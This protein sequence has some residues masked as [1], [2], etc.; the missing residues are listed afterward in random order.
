MI[1]LKCKLLY[2][3]PQEAVAVN[4]RRLSGRNAGREAGDSARERRRT[5]DE[6]LTQMQ[7]TPST[8]TQRQEH[9]PTNSTHPPRSYS[10]PL[11]YRIP[12]LSRSTMVISI[13]IIIPFTPS[14]ATRLWLLRRTAIEWTLYY[15]SSQ[16]LFPPSSPHPASILKS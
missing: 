16:L 10:I 9:I 12:N 1:S 15:T 5:K 2:C 6:T 7:I 8:W 3:L 14:S 13:I 11:Q 4:E